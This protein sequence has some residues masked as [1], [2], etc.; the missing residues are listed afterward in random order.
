MDIRNRMADIITLRSHI[1]QDFLK[2]VIVPGWQ[3]SLYS[4]AAKEIT[5]KYRGSYKP[6]YDKM[7][8]VGIEN[9]TVDMMDVTGISLVINYC[10]TIVSVSNKTRELLRE[11]TN[12]RNLNQHSC[13]NEDTE[14]LYLQA[15]LDLCVLLRFVRTVDNTEISID[16]DKRLA[17]RQKYVKECDT[18][19][20]IIDEERISLI[21]FDKDIQQD[22]DLIKNSSEP[23]KMWSKIIEA[24]SDRAWHIEKNPEIEFK[25]AVR[26]SDAGIPFAHSYAASYYL[27]EKNYPEV[28]KRIAMMLQADTVNPVSKVCA[29]IDKINDLLKKRASIS[30]ELIEKLMDICPDGYKIVLEKNGLY[31]L[32]KMK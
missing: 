31:K 2:L 7:R 32:C 4:A 29:I 19:K 9:Y 23:A 5:G 27:Y 14:E 26:A 22:I 28:E 10:P 21:K 1:C 12:D 17:F 11:V 8:D 20:D 30:N 15:L 13:G 18:L 25:F 24:R 3:Q 6:I 16:N